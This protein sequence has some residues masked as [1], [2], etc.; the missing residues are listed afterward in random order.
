[1][2]IWI[3]RLTRLLVSWRCGLGYITYLVVLL[4][5]L[6]RGQV[7][8]NKLVVSIEGFG[9]GIHLLFGLL[10]YAFSDHAFAK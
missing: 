7:A 6:S 1:M 8:C 4:A 5:R 9:L 3:W 2:R 10:G